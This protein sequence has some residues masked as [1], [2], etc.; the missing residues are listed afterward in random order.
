M[1]FDR[2]MCG[3]IGIGARGWKIVPVV[4]MGEWLSLVRREFHFFFSFS[5]SFLDPFGAFEMGCVLVY[6]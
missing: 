2:G 4:L 1:F 5:F 6:L 3:I